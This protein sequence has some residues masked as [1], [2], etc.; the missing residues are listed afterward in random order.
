M[1]AD[2]LPTPL[3]HSLHGAVEKRLVK[4]EKV[5]QDGALNDFVHHI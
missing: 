3:V 5:Y 4:F 2:A 1:T